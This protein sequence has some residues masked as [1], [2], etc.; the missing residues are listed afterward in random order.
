MIDCI[1][2]CCSL[3]SPTKYLIGEQGGKKTKKQNYTALK[4]KKTTQFSLQNNFRETRD[5]WK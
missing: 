5:L 1:E 3:P 2:S 4:L